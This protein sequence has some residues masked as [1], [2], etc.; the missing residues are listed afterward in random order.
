M[1]KLILTLVAALGL[2]FALSSTAEAAAPAGNH[3]KV[4]GKISAIDAPSHTFVVT[5]P[6]GSK[7][8]VKVTPK[9]KL[10]VDGQAATFADLAVGQKAT[11]VGK[12]GPGGQLLVAA[13]VR[14]KS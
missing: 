14:A 7:R 2:V 13:R 3:A 9:T 4:A 5:R 10:R 12:K 8:K 1:S 6:D 11:A